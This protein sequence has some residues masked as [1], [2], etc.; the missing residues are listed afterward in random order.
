[1]ERVNEK[2]GMCMCGISRVLVMRHWV[3]YTLLFKVCKIST[4]LIV[5]RD[6]QY[7]LLSRC[8]RVISV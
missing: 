7:L 4:V 3:L 8:G 6:E 2:S 1:M 5:V